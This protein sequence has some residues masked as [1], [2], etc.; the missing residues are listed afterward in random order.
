MKDLTKEVQIFACMFAVFK[1]CMR[2]PG[3]G[4][5]TGPKNVAMI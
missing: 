2:W 3:E 1:V 5:N 4:P